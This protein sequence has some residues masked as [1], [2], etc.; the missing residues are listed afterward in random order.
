MTN[1]ENFFCEI[2][3]KPFEKVPY[4]LDLCGSLQEKFRAEYNT[5]DFESLF[6][7]PFRRVELNPSRCPVD[8]TRYFENLGHV[9][10]ID[11]WGV[12]YRNGSVAHFASFVS[13]MS[14]FETPEEVKKFPL[15]DMLEAYRWEGIAEK[16][17]QLKQ[18]DYI[19]MN[20]TVNIDIFEPSWYLR[21]MENLLMDMIADEEM[22]QACLDRIAE[23]KTKLAAKFAEAGVDVLVFGDD[24]G[25]ERGM[26]MSADTWRKWLKP[27]LAR[28]IQ[29]AKEVKPDILCYYHSDGDIREIIP[30]LIEVGVDIL[31]PI[32]P[33]CM[34]PVEIY[35]TYS[36]KVAFWGTIGTQTTMPFGSVKDVEEKTME[37]LRLCREKGRLVIAP[38]HLL[39]PEVP[40]ENIMT[41]VNTVRRFNGEKD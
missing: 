33:E 29:A 23:I 24:V 16:V 18:Q 19:V 12:G 31:N 10:R 20:G 5:D 8:Y 13:P 25:T 3:G 27:R 37:M 35:N 32:Q 7:C 39:E 40:V 28:A 36:E 30:E 9:D 4:M 14:L 22:A 11:E 15:P 17:Q 21:G 34:D 1:R 38:T 41:F 6:G 2:Q 26:M